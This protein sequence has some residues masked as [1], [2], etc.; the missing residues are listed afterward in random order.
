MVTAIETLK[1]W[2]ILVNIM[3]G[4]LKQEDSKFETPLLTSRC[5]LKKIIVTY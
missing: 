1:Q 5:C 2:C 4:K 3:F